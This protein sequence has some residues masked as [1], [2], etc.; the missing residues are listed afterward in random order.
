MKISLTELWL[1]AQGIGD[2]GD[3]RL[4]CN[5]LGSNSD[6]RLMADS[7]VERPLSVTES[8]ACR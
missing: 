3:E 7:G 4:V 8:L 1:T 5:G 6:R 2:P